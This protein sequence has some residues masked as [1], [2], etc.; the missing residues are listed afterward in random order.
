MD[1]SQ[2]VYDCINGD[3]RAFR[4]L[5]DLHA[6]FAY[7]VACRMVNDEDEAKDIVQETFISVW[8]SL[9]KFDP[10]RC[11]KSWLYRIIVNKCMDVLRKRKKTT[12]LHIEMNDQLV[13][14][15][16]RS[17]NQEDHLN[18]KELER[19]IEIATQKLS[20]KQKAVFVLSELEGL[21]HDEIVEITKM[22]KDAIKSNLN[23][24]KRSIGRMIEKYL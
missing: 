5:V 10:A 7:A 2:I 6:D 14:V 16:E 17:G 15:L 1:T 11:F 24:A 23:H 8:R 22:G 18:K 21:S 13:A 12:F 19:L 4:R 9:G 20:P 3:E